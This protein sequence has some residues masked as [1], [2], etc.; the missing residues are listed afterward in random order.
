MDRYVI[1]PNRV[2]SEAGDYYIA[3][4]LKAYTCQFEFVVVTPALVA[5]H[6]D[7]N[8][9]YA[10]QWAYANTRVQVNEFA[11]LC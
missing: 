1:T 9:I 5:V 7:D 11:A 4:V 2:I 10:R 8:Y 3:R 6:V